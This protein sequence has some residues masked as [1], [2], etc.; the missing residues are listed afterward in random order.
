MS[1]ELRANLSE[2]A[3]LLISKIWL[4]FLTAAV[5]VAGVFFYSEA[6]YRPY[7]V[8]STSF[9]VNAKQNGS[10][11]ANRLT[12]NDIMLAQELVETY[13]LVLRSNL[14]MDAVIERLGLNM[15]AGRLGSS[16]RL[17]SV[18]DT[19]VLYLE[20]TNSN[21]ELAIA[22][23]DT[24]TEIAPEVM[25]KT[26]EIGSINVLDKA[27]LIGVSPRETIP[28]CSAAGLIGLIVSVL[29][30]IAGKALHPKIISTLTIELKL[31]RRCLFEL[32]Q[33]KRRDRKTSLLLTSRCSER[34][35]ESYLKMGIFIKSALDSNRVKKLLVTSVLEGEGKTMVAIN[36][37][38]ALSKLGHSVLLIDGNLK[39]PS[40]KQVFSVS[41]DQTAIFDPDSEEDT[42]DNFLARIQPNL[43]VMPYIKSSGSRLNFNSDKFTLLLDVYQQY[44]D[45]IVFD[46]AP[47]SLTTDA[48]NLAAISDAVLMVI[49]QNNTR[50]SGAI[51]TIADLNMVGAEVIG[52][53]LNGVKYRKVTALAREVRQA[54]EGRFFGSFK[55]I[56]SE[57]DAQAT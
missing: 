44:F 28:N 23:A 13:T 22:I 27:H 31:N 57:K 1:E 26:V 52:C 14:V 48:I 6:T 42:Q 35:A 41:K 45:Y 46:S 54:D 50:V 7:Y 12:A 53:V 11:S 30:I 25:M 21:R 3:Y 29:Y 19:Q 37:A 56:L 33:V 47:I 38:L 39:K 4:I 43:F 5:F 36:L 40:L 2:I 16:I 24:I 17:S 49:K 34:Y 55:R 18:K 15:D 32:A 51:K 9:V 8:A 10:Y 20:V